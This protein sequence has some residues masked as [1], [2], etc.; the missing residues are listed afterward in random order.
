M[1]ISNLAAL[2]IVVAA[3]FLVIKLLTKPIKLAFKLLLNSLIGFVVLALIN[4]FLGLGITMV[5]YN[6]LLVG[7]LGVPGLIVVVVLHF[8]L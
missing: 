1:D 4:F 3:V 7:F 6:Y 8:L 2:A 5:W